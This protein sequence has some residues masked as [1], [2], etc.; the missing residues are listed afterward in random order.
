MELHSYAKRRTS[1]K[2]TIEQKRKLVEARIAHDAWFT[3]KP[4]SV[5]PWKNV[6]IVAKLDDF[7]V[8][9]VRKQWSNMLTRYKQYKQT[10]LGSTKPI[11]AESIRRINQ[12]WEFFEPIHTFMTRK[13]TNLHSYAL[14]HRTD[15]NNE[16]Q[17]DHGD[18]VQS[19]N[20]EDQNSRKSPT[21]LQNETV[22]LSLQQQDCVKENIP[23]NTTIVLQSNIDNNNISHDDGIHLFSSDT[24]EEYQMIT[25]DTTRIINTAGEEDENMN[26][27][28]NTDHDFYSKRFA[29]GM[30]AIEIESEVK[31]QEE[32]LQ[33]QQVNYFADASEDSQ[34]SLGMIVDINPHTSSSVNP[35]NMVTV[36]DGNGQTFEIKSENV[37][38]TESICLKE[39]FND[40][41][42]STSTQRNL[43]QN[44]E[45]IPTSSTSRLSERDKYYRHKRRFN[46]RLEK[47]FDAILQVM[48][49]IVKAEYP[50]VDVTPLMGTV[51]TVASTMGQLFSS[52]SEGEDNE[53]VH[54]VIND[55]HS[56][57]TDNIPSTTNNLQQ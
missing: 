11:D 39:E 53:D 31:I 35:I 52:E 9:F 6:L 14:T 16:D 30:G 49:Q 17:E 40:E 43:T 8:F 32:Q 42:P 29:Q 7:N 19:S 33:E 45:N 26:H 13:T 48:S 41:L 54:S 57:A 25:G 21:K 47:R 5:V 56:D 51:N 38:E 2:W 34:G 23:N 44:T 20:T 27:V 46:R 15:N 28:R 1:K 18:L 50:S 55:N 4:S 22:I 37:T 10:R 12:E 3:S 36:R 24:N